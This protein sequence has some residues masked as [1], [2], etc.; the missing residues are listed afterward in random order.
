LTPGELAA[1]A[2]IDLWLDSEVAAHY[3]DQPLAQDWA[4]VAKAAE[5]A[6][7]AVDALIRLTGQNPRKGMCGTLEE[8]LSELADVAWTGVFAIQHFTKDPDMT[9]AVLNARLHAILDRVP[10]A[11]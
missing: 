7:E 5:E 10:D 8:L 9:D 11:E 6:G 2:V 4:R 1:V 3:K